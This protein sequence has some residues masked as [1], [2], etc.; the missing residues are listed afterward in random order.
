MRLAMA[1]VVDHFID[2]TFQ[3]WLSGQEHFAVLGGLAAMA[4]VF[5]S[6]RRQNPDWFS[7]RGSFG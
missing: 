1:F 2:S 5:V 6:S 7:A 3:H 4:P